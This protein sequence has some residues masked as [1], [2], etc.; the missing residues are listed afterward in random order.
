[1]VCNNCKN[2]VEPGNAFCASC[3]SRVEVGLDTLNSNYNEQASSYREPV[4]VWGWVG[5]SLIS[6][7]P[8]V[9]PLIYLIMLFVWSFNKTKEQTFS[10]WAKAQLIMSLFALILVVII[11]IVEVIAIYALGVGASSYYY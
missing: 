3:G 1:M 6:C 4:S 11:L 5:R 8:F 7:I 10:N 2:P 9:G